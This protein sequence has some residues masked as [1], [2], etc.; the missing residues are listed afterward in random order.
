MSIA[1]KISG[2]LLWFV[3]LSLPPF[4][5]LVMFLDWPLALSLGAVVGGLFELRAV[6]KNA[7]VFNI[8]E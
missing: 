5:F 8:G 4:F 3:V 7:L 6:H 1:I 2:L